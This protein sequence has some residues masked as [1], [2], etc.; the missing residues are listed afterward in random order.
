MT[1]PE[2]T[3]GTNILKNT[4]CSIYKHYFSWRIL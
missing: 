3:I 1:D 2:E 4:W